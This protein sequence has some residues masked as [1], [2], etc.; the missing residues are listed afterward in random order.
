MAFNPLMVKDY[1]FFLKGNIA[2]RNIYSILENLE[3]AFCVGN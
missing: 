3:G 2:R 1:N